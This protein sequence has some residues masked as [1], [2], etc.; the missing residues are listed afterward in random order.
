MNS[1]SAS[2]HLAS[3][4][5]TTGRQSAAYT[6]E[7]KTRLVVLEVLKR[8]ATSLSDTERERLAD[9]IIRYSGQHDHDPFL[10]LAVIETESSFRRSVVSSK[11]AVGLMQVRPFVAKAQARELN[12]SEKEATR[13]LDPATNVMIGTHYLAKMRKRFGNLSLA[14]EAYNRG[15]TKLGISIRKGHKLKKKYTARVLRSRERLMDMVNKV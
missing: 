7:D 9:A 2:Y 10:V 11:G 5:E 8:R 3:L 13:L 12:I 4:N 6:A 15:P 1:L 14:L